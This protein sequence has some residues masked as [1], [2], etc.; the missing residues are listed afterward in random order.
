MNDLPCL[1]FKDLSMRHLPKTLIAAALGVFLSANACA[2][3]LW[4]EQRRGHLEAVFGDGAE[5]DAYKPS[6]IKAAT[7]YDRAGKPLAVT[8]E[9]QA[10]HARFK[11]ASSPA[12][13][14]VT[15]DGGFWAQKPDQQWVAQGKRQVP[16]AIDSL[17]SVRYS[18]AV[19]EE[20]AR[21]EVPKDVH[22]VIVPQADPLHVGVGKALPVQV[23]LDGKPARDVEL[24]GD[25]RGAPH[26]VSAKTDADGRAS[27][28]VRNDGLNI[29]AAY[30]SQDVAKDADVDKNSYFTS[31]TFIGTPE[32]E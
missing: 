2:H 11:P 6:E 9:P 12:T 27:V 3:G 26:T 20:K 30:T 10:D 22:F 15:M 23:L 4:T 25:F 8:I 18:L 24:M 28:P 21:I 29:I 16:G 7:A 17:R 1:P 14:F 13:L 31:L 5:D 19:L 32:H